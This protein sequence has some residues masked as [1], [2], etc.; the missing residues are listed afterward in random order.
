M[1]LLAR[2]ATQPRPN[3]RREA[4]LALGL[5]CVLALAFLLFPLDVAVAVGLVGWFAVLA[6]VDVR[7][8]VLALIVARSSVDVAAELDLALGG[9]LADLNVAAILSAMLVVLGV[10]HI[11]VNR[12]DVSKIPLVRPVGALLAVFSVGVLYAPDAGVAFQGWLRTVSAFV[13][14]LLVVDML[15]DRKRTASVV[16]AI[17]VSAVVPVLVGLYQI[18]VGGANQD[19]EGFSRITAT[20]VHPSPYAIYLVTLLPLAIVAFLHARSDLSR[21]GLGLLMMAMMVCLV[22][23]FTRGAWIGFL[24]ALLVMAAVKY[25]G[26]LLLVPALVLLILI[27]VPPVQERFAELG[28]P[29]SSWDWRTNQWADALSIQSVW[30]RMTGAGLG[31]VE[32]HL[33]SEAHNDYLKVWVEAGVLGSLAFFWLYAS[34]LRTA[35][36]GYRGLRSDYQRSL[37]LAFIAVLAGRAVMLLSD[38]LIG[39]PVLE[40]YFWSLAAV[41]VALVTS[42]SAAGEM[43]PRSASLGGEGRVR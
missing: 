3:V 32:Y 36:A 34:L 23:T 26:A 27:A 15:R 43:S 9:P 37:A 31:A 4:P 30:Q 7:A 39:H 18:V 11:A 25:R 2:A 40:W 12:V 19:T 17:L 16:G 41:V 1:T 22:A 38:N 13:L 24:V 6:M 14:Y 33:A 20:F 35:I 5:G 28:G 29:Y 42:P 21:L 8:T 10:V